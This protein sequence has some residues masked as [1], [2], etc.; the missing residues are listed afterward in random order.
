MRRH[1][2]AEVWINFGDESYLLTG[3]IT[4]LLKHAYS[5]KVPQAKMALEM[6]FTA[7]RIAQTTERPSVELEKTGVKMEE[8]DAREILF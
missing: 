8:I 7:T 4:R 5:T 3:R 1:L 6:E 2:P